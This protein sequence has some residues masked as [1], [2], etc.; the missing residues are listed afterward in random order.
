[1]QADWARRLDGHSHGSGTVCTK[2]G[3]ATDGISDRQFRTLPESRVV[4]Q[5]ARHAPITYNKGRGFRFS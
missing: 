2:Y 5:P 1:M 4:V 3:F